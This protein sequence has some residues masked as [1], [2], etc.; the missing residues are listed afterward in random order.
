MKKNNIKVKI[1]KNKIPVRFE[2]RKNILVIYLEE[3]RNKIN[4]LKP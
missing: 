2:L 1:P 4:R 3:K